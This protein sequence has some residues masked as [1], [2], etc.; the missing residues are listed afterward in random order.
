MNRHFVTLALVALVGVVACRKEETGTPLGTTYAQIA[1]PAIWRVLPR[2]QAETLRLEPGDVVVSYNDEPLTT[3]EELVQLQFKSVAS[4]GRI[5][6]TVMRGD[7]EMKL[8]AEPGVLGVLPDAERYP[9]GLAVALKDMLGYYGVTADYDWLAALTGESFAFTAR[10]SGCRGAW[11]NGLAGDYLEGLTR[12]YG[13]TL[14]PVFAADADTA[15]PDNDVKQE[16]VAALRD[17]LGR[18]K[19]LLVFGAWPAAN[20]GGWGV[21]SR[22][23]P[24]D[25]LVYGYTLGSAGEVALKGTFG[26]AYEAGHR[27]AE[28]YDPAEMLTTVLSQALE[29]GQAYADTGWQ[30]GVA[31]YDIWIRGLDTIPFCP[32]CPDSG[33]ACFDRLIWTLLANKESAN[34]F[35]Q[36]MREALPDQTALLDEIIAQ[37]SAIIGKLNGIIQSGVTI[38]TVERQQKLARSVNEIQLAETNLLSLYEELI[39]EL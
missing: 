17:R 5:P 18:G 28:E 27:P 14:R 24:D 22:C 12:Y 21:A 13:L 29:L 39:G 20:G 16:A 9:G 37:N 19:P 34:R 31:A 36:D 38:G 2:T 8:E 7:A 11:P 32:V 15:Q 26:E 3:T 1:R 10:P 4:S 25:S 6:M 30:S 33:R 35:L 23:D